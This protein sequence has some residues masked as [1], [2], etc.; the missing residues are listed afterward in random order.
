MSETAQH[1]DLTT[2]AVAAQNAQTAS[3]GNLSDDSIISQP[4]PHQDPS[5]ENG[6]EDVQ[7]VPFSAA[8]FEAFEKLAGELKLSPD[9]VEKL[10]A[11]SADCAAHNAQ[12]AAEEKRAQ[13]TAWANETRAFYGAKLDEEIAFALRAA[14]TFGGPELR[15]LLEETGLGNHPVI[16]RTLSG[17]G[18]TISE[19]ASLGGVPTAP[20]DKTFAQA[21]Y[22]SKN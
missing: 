20:Q 18:R 8:D 22:E 21:L 9:Q 5:D 4:Q 16:I 2:P 14:D 3:E 10:L 11:F 1:T 6:S 19:D 13:A 17:I 12:S 7:R 15:E